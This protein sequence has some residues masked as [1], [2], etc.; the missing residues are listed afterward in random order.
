MLKEELTME[1]IVYLVS[2]ISVVLERE[3]YTNDDLKKLREELINS[4][5]DLMA[6]KGIKFFDIEEITPEQLAH[7]ETSNNTFI[8][9]YE[10]NT[11][12]RKNVYVPENLMWLDYD[13]GEVVIGEPKDHPEYPVGVSGWVEK[14]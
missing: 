13:K 12:K 6:E 8:F 4:I 14:K 11:K 9:L 2:T 7:I 10:G 5:E 3:Y 1:A